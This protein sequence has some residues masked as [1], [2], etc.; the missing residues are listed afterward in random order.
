M[1]ALCVV[2]PEVPITSMMVVP[3][4]APE[5]LVKVKVDDPFPGEERVVGLNLAEMPVGNWEAESATVPLKPPRTAAVILTLPLVVELTMTAVVLDVSD[6]PGTLTVIVCFCV[7][8]P[9]LA[10][11]VME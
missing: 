3:V 4:L 9:P 5:P 1:P 7:T 10:L 2:D 11:T 8:P 6:S